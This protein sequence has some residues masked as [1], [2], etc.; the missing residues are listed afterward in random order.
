MEI[1]LVSFFNVE[2]GFGKILTQGHPEGIFVHYTDV[3]GEAKILVENELVEFWVTD[4]E[5]GPKAQEV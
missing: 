1:G 4:T 3:L 2:R 5:K